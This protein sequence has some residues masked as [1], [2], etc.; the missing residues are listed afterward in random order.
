MQCIFCA[1]EIKDA[2]QLCRF[3]GARLVD[4]QWCHPLSPTTDKPPRNF[5][6]FS[7]GWL[8]VLSGVWM[9]VTCT[10]PV[11]LFGELRGG[12]VAVLYHGLLSA[13]FLAMGYALATRKPWALAATA[14]ASVAYTLDKLMYLI[15]AKA[16]QASLVESIQFF[17]TLG[18]GMSDMIDQVAVVLSLAFLAC[19]WGLCVY[20]YIK[21]AYFLPDRGGTPTSR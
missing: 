19:W 4:G 1:E 7:T 14:A 21:R 8:L 6:L 2:A 9:L 11:P 20:I 18:E 13:S 5:T 15:D 10:S 12:A 17:D 16:R 3:C